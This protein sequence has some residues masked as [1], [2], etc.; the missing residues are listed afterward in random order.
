MH[1]HERKNDELG[2]LVAYTALH[3]VH[4]HVTSIE[5]VW[6]AYGPLRVPF[7]VRLGSIL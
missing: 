5:S 6:I 2:P 4:G 7:G 1:A 3:T